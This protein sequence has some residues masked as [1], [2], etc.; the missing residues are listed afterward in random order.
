MRLSLKKRRLGGNI[1]V[2]QLLGRTLEPFGG[3]CL[4]QGTGLCIYETNRGCRRLV[5]RC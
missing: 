5:V 1:T 3:L 4:S 2:L